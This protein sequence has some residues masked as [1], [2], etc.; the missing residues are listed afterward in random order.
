[1]EDFQKVLVS[2]SFLDTTHGKKGCTVCH[3]G[4]QGTTRKLA[5]KDMI[6][7]PSKEKTPI[8]ESC[9]EQAMKG[10]KNSLHYTSKGIVDTKTG[11][12]MLRANPEKTATLEKGLNT[13][14]GTCHVATCGECHI[15]RPGTTGG[16]LV[17]G[18]NFYKSPKS[19]L[20]CTACHGSRLE[21]EY[22]G[23]AAED[24]PDLKPDVHWVPGSMQ[25]VTCHKKEWIHGESPTADN[26][27]AVQNG[28]KCQDCHAGKAE[29][30]NI[31]AHKK[32]ALQAEGSTMLQCQVC[33]S[34]SYNNCY[35]CHVGVDDKKLPY[36]KTDESG[37]DF[38]IG[39]N[40]EKTKDRPYDY[41]IVRHVPVARDTFKFYG[42]DLLSQFDNSPTWKYSTPHNVQR[43]TPQG[44]CT[45]CHGNSKIFL[46]EKDVRPDELKANAKVIVKTIP[47]KM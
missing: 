35:G 15:T 13:N 39:R 30:N 5:H 33:H 11:T 4:S 24:Y 2:K 27:Y 21:K 8:C 22:M 26:R 14:C 34:Q 36:Y 12:I 46:T 9:H 47:P 7:Y 25:C 18:H 44:Q 45:G 1:M 38:K 32:H 28:A 19:V 17:D 23:K 6:A 43:V 42:E 29:F 40:P 20:N 3:D 16:G 10:F 31:P 37:F 41:T